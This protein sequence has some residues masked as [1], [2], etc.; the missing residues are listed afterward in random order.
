MSYEN[1]YNPR[2]PR[3]AE[4]QWTDAGSAIRAAASDLD[5]VRGTDDE[6]GK[7]YY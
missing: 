4:G 5:I 3:D 1:H 7:S 2:Q 6:M